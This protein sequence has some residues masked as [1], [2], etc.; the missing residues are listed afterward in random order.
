MQILVERKKLF[1]SFIASGLIIASIILMKGGEELAAAKNAEL[2]AQRQTGAALFVIGWVG[3][4][5]LFALGT[6]GYKF[7][8]NKQTLWMTASVLLVVTA[9]M[10]MEVELVKGQTK[11]GM[12]AMLTIG[13]VSLSGALTWKKS[14]ETKIIALL[15]SGALI[16]SHFTL[17][18][19]RDNCMVHG[20]GMALIPA[21]FSLL[22]FANARAY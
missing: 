17:P 4:V 14:W 13:L 18:Y 10:M 1:G 5:Y 22:I 12:D 9:M 16:S 8:M 19:Q 15:G 6:E 3:L 11:Q 7:Q 20:P 21:G 2:N